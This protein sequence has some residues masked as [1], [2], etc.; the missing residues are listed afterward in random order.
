MNVEYSNSVYC[1]YSSYGTYIS[2]GSN[3][4]NIAL[5]ITTFYSVVLL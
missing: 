5:Y 1:M 3:Q 2:V 4:L